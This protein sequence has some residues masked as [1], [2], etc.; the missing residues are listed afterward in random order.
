LRHEGR[1]YVGVEGATGLDGEE[2]GMKEGKGKKWNSG[3]AG[4]E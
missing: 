4:I 1:R 2:D 3:I